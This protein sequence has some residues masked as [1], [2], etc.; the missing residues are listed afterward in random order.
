M[1]GCCAVEGRAVAEVDGLCNVDAS[2][3]QVANGVV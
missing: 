3:L 1:E 2:L